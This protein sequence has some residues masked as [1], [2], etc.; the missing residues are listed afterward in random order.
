M[1]KTKEGMYREDKSS[2]L[3]FLD[4]FTPEFM[5]RYGRHMK[6]GELRH[7]R[8]NFKKG[9][10]PREEYLQS[11]MRH[12]VAVWEEYETGEKIGEEDHEMSVVFNILGFT[13]EVHLRNLSPPTGG[14][15]K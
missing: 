7:G 8:G 10:Y 6:Q 9:G 5:N 15:K 4:Y 13:H 11:A 1:K 12:L 2:K 14:K 3:N